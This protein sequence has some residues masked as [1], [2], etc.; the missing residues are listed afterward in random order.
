MEQASLVLALAMGGAALL[1]LIGTQILNWYWLV[2]LFAGSLAFGIF[3]T[4]R[5]VHPPYVLAQLID[6]RLKLYDAFSTAFH[7]RAQAGS[8]DPGVRAAQAE[9]AEDL[10]RRVDLRQALPFAAPRFLYASAGLALVALGMFAL[11]YGVMHSMDLRPSLL[12]AAFDSLFEQRAMAA[13]NDPI[14][15]RMEEEY[16]KLAAQEESPDVQAAADHDAAPNSAL[17]AANTSESNDPSTASEPKAQA[18]DPQAEKPGEQSSDDATQRDAQGK[19]PS[20]QQ[21]GPDSKNG[22]QAAKQQQKQNGGKQDSNSD[23]SSLMDKM[24]DFAAN[25]MN[26]LKNQ[27]KDQEGQ[28]SAANKNQSGNPQDKMSQKGSPSQNKSNQSSEQSQDQQGDPQGDSNQKG[29]STQAKSTAKADHNAEQDGKSGIGHE[30][31]DKSSREAEQLQAMGKISEI[32]GKRSANVT[33]EVMVEVS[34]GKQQLKTQYSQK[35]GSH[36]ESGSEINRDEVPLIYQQFVQQY[37][38]QI[39]KAPAPPASAPK[40][41]QADPGSKRPS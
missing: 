17:D 5:R 7:F 25:L 13:K 20:G 21:N 36:A 4:A 37:F 22:N 15:K 32:L 40:A 34:S 27:S 18:G 23:N 9:Q 6:R 31:G 35:V 3:R 33:G 26:K 39:H 11:R 24:R 10:A 16:Q 28:Q 12:S 30:D 1:L 2:L 8:A 41:K 14:A 29:Q 38:E 19:Q